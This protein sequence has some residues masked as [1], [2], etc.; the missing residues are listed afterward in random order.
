MK[1]VFHTDNIDQIFYRQIIMEYIAELGQENLTLFKRYKN[2]RDHW[3]IHIH[4]AADWN[5]VDGRSSNT[6]TLNAMIPHGVTGE[7]IVKTYIIDVDDKGLTS[8][9]N[10]S[11]ILHEVAHMYLIATLRG[12]RGTYRNNDLSGNKKGSEAN[13]STQEVHDHQMERKMYQVRT[14]INTGNWIIRKWVRYSAVGLDL[15]EFLKKQ[16]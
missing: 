16:L 13:V 7:G 4:P 14:W 11:A 2:V 12:I 8:L 6:G 10:F 1:I 9:Q 15:R 3:T 5:G